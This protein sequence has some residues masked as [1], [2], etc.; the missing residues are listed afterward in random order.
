[1]LEIDID[2]FTELHKLTSLYFVLFVFHIFYSGLSHDELWTQCLFIDE[3]KQS[4]TLKNME[5][6]KK[7]PCRRMC[8]CSKITSRYTLSVPGDWSTWLL[9]N[10]NN[11]IGTGCK[12][13]LS[14]HSS[15]SRTRSFSCVS[16]FPRGRF[17]IYN[18]ILAKVYKKIFRSAFHPEFN[19]LLP[20]FSL[21]G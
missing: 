7:A 11:S 3:F 17:K 13:F 8:L 1:M 4:L 10:E 18:F 9:S 5:D 19:C 15:L 20:L 16:I 6:Y 12:L 14:F 21:D 2:F